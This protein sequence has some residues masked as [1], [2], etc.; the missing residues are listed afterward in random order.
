MRR[1]HHIDLYRLSGKPE[2]FAPLNLDHVYQNC[3]AL[4][5]WPVRLPPSLQ[6]PDKR[7][8]DIDIRILPSSTKKEGN[9][10]EN[11]RLLT[12]SFPEGSEWKQHLD[13]IRQEGYLDD[14]LVTDQIGSKE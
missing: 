1:I 12:L 14:M 9:D 4:I 2:D 6:P 11:S 5:E 3:I 10:D 7:R 8:L 13:Q